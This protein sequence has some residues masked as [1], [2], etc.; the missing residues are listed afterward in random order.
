MD[1]LAYLDPGSGS[2]ILQILA[3]GHRR[4]GRH[5]QAVL[6]PAAQVPAHP[7]GRR[8]DHGAAGRLRLTRRRASR[9]SPAVPTM[10]RRPPPRAIASACPPTP[11]L[12]PRPTRRSSSRAPSGTRRAAS[13][14]R[15]TACYR[16]LS[17]DGPERLQGAGGDQGLEALQRERRP[18]RH[19]ARSTAPSG[20]PAGLVKDSAGVL[21]HERIP[22]VSY[23][24]EW[25]FSMLKDAALL[26]L[27]LTLAALEEDMILKDSTPYNVQFRGAQPGVRGRRLV[28]APARGRAVGRLP[29]VLHALP[30]PAAAAG[31][32]G[33]GPA[34]RCCAATSTAS[35]PRR[36]A[37]WSRFRDRFRKGF[38]LNVFLHAKLEQRH[39]DRGKEVK[40]EV[41][42]AGFKKELIRGQRH[43]DAQARRGPG[44]EPAA[45]R[46]G[47]LRR[48]QQLHRR[49]R[50]AQ[51]RVRPRGG[52]LAAAGT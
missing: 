43:A 50:Q 13:S 31:G 27:D 34:A 25:P 4:G 18:G 8:G 21:K 10:F 46:L 41:K 40:D 6:G 48:A 14:T 30:L 35:R 26:Q 42:K 52:H 5:R 3:G 45:G 37:A 29:P 22:F 32:E 7:Q 19:R 20:L 23:P 49:R 24:Y 2:M 15:A 38:Y 51:G 17:A 28:R 1:L 9:A 33:R 36:C 16:A 12:P 39:G 11:R 44:V 47:G